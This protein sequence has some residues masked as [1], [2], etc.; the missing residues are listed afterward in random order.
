MKLI[1]AML[2][3]FVLI[4]CTWSF[5]NISTHG[6]ATDLVDEEQTTSPNVSPNVDV[7]LG[8]MPALGNQM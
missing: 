6:S 5:Q 8:V 7:P 3:I 2:L 1:I 4:G